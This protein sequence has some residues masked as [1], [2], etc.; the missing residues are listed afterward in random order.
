MFNTLKFIK[1]QDPS[2]K[3]YLEIIFLYPGYHAIKAHRVAH[4]FYKIRLYFIAR[5]IMNI[6]RFFTQIEIH[7]GATIAKNVFIDHGS[8][9]VIGETA[10]IEENVVLFHGVTLGGRGH[11]TE[12]KRHPT[13]KRGAMIA[14]GAKILGNVTVGEN[15]KVGASTTVLTDIPP[16]STAV[17]PKARIIEKAVR[18]MYDDDLC[19]FDEKKRG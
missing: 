7:P 5:L 3:S 11:E 1:K 17:G 12:A 19:L 18:E 6:A 16:N 13:I 2:A 8:G 14:A 15:A 4:I 9:T 10:I